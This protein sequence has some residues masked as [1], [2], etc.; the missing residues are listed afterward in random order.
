MLL[1]RPGKLR[2][3]PTVSFPYRNYLS[4][5]YDATEEKRSVSMESIPKEK[6]QHNGRLVGRDEYY[7]AGTLIGC[8]T[9]AISQ[10][11]PFQN[12]PDILFN[13]IIVMYIV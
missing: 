10:K 4:A 2:N 9:L 5:V 1:E 12:R 13:S 3:E 11:I 8:I 7:C 6:L